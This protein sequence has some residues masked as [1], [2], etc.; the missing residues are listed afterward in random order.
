MPR[1][2]QK[3][4]AKVYLWP[5]MNLPVGTLDRP[6]E[7]FIASLCVVSG[8]AQ[9]VGPAEQQSVNASLPDPIVIFW[10]LML[11]IGGL[12]TVVG[13]TKSWIRCERAG[14][15]LLSGASAIYSVC[16]ISY[17]GINSIFTVCITLA[18][19]AATAL[20]AMMVGVQLQALSAMRKELIRVAEEARRVG[21]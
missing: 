20:R 13:V 1:R 4:R 9:L 21:I 5:V 8:L 11:S 10:S 19:S 2:L 7:S 12:T 15:E 3:I 17:L 16:A 6:I 18:F 14:L